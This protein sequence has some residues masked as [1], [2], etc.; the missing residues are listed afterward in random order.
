LLRTL[1]ITSG[2]RAIEGFDLWRDTMATAIGVTSERLP[3]MPAVFSARMEVTASP[4]L[5]HIDFRA[6]NSRVERLRPQ[7]RDVPWGRYWLYREMGAGAWF[8][9]GGT[10]EFST[11]PGD[12]ILAD[13]DAAF[14][15]RANEHYRHHIWMLPYGVL[16]PHLPQLPRPL[17]VHIPATSGITPLVTA[18]ID[19]LATSLTGLSEAQAVMVADNLG[20]LLA[21]ACGGAIG[22]HEL[23]VRQAV[24]AQAR[25]HIEQHLTSPDLN[26][27]SV[28]R[29]LGISVRQLHLVFERSGESFGRHVRRRRLQECRATLESPLATNRSITDIAFGWGFASLPTFY[30]AFSQTFGMA[31]GD[32]RPRMLGGP[33]RP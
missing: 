12:I 18:Y 21:I 31:P 20:R 32:V 22:D 19:A 27:D 24:L 17:V 8:E 10:R 15:T 11:R 25:Q 7:I 1:F 2:A 29:A 33:D 14:R 26:P 30:R 9:F 28:A 13:A 23:A 5:T 16:D 3:D 6:H 4:S